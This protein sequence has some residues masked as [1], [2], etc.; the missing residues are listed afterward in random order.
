MIRVEKLVIHEFRGIRD[1]TLAPSGRNFAI[2]GPNGTGKSGVVDAIEFALTGEISRLSGRGTGGL[3]VKAHGPH[4]DSRDKPGD[5]WVEATVFVPTLNTRAT[6][7][8]TV[9]DAKSPII[10]PGNPKVAAI[11]RE[12]ATHPE[13]VLSRRELI[14]YVLSEPGKRSEEV[15]AL[16]RLDELET[17]RGNLQKIANATDREVTTAERAQTA[18]GDQLMRALGIAKLTDQEVL[19][20][21]NARRNTLSLPA[22]ERL[23]AASSIRDGLATG[24][25]TSG[26]ERQVSKAQATSDLQAARS[27]IAAV[28]T[29]S[30]RDTIAACITSLEEL[31]A[32]PTII[33]GASREALLRSAVELFDDAHCPVCDTDWE[34]DAFRLLVAEKRA[35]LRDA[36]SRRDAAEKQLEPI[37]LCLDA[38]AIALTT[39]ARYGQL[40][41][42]Q[43]DVTQIATTAALAR[44]DAVTL[45]QLLPLADTIGCLTRRQHVLD[46][47]ALLIALEAAIGALPEPSEKDAA[48]DFLTIGQEKLEVWRSATTRLQ[49]LR[50]RATTARTVFDLFGASVTDALET[51]YKEVE[52]RFID[53][54]RVVNKEDEGSFEAKLTPSLGKL[55]FDVDFY[56]RGF[57]PPGAYHSEGH[58][59]GMGVCLYLALM[60]HLLGSGF[61]FAVLDDVLMSVDA[62]HRREVCRMLNTQFPH[63]QF[64]LT[65]HDDI[66]LRHMSSEGLVASKDRVHFRKWDVAIGPTEWDDGDIWKEIEEDLGRGDVRATAALL[67]HYLEYFGQEA[68]HRLRARVEF[69]ADANFMLGD[70]L[71]NAVGALGALLKSGRAAATS[72]KQD[73]V[74]SAIQSREDEFAV[75]RTAS[76]VDQWQVNAA[77]HFNAWADLRREDFQ[78]VVTA[79]RSLVGQFICDACEGVIYVSPER[80]PREELRCGCG[81]V[82]INLKTKPAG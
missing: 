32:D 31:E 75:A 19:T 67:R 72:W 5:A 71:P 17:I 9:K 25:D 24:T 51:I 52:N 6:L 22:M 48:R 3:S 26:Q 73:Q 2:C 68:C 4:V 13:F 1:L 77:V 14:K 70:T 42:P 29:D 16:L 7:R 80:G 55:G 47:G 82:H 53:L 27:A 36:V 54:Y 38:L 10:K 62:G 33:D 37:S 21:V 66:W 61:T 57:F 59:D 79:F 56:G 30:F 8:R 20:A 12:V 34:P 50:T 11:L 43:I 81:V 41:V 49:R 46:G 78:P 64:I 28:A 23:E 44:V 39:P 40:L 35:K 45:R 65:T 63:T 18:A 69:R 60:D 58:Q 74:L 15:Q 76:N